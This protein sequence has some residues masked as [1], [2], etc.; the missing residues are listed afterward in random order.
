MQVII[1]TYGT[2]KSALR[3]DCNFSVKGGV[4]GESEIL[5]YLLLARIYQRGGADTLRKCIT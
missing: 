4:I 2:L 5:D 1:T 3:M